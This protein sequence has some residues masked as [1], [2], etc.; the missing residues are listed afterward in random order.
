MGEIVGPAGNIGDGDGDGDDSAWPALVGSKGKCNVNGASFSDATAIAQGNR[1]G[2]VAA[3]VGT[4]GKYHGKCI[5]LP[6]DN[7]P[8]II[9]DKVYVHEFVEEDCYTIE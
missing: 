2:A 8:S 1:N 5:K 4:E 7:F 6:N 3:I 9:E